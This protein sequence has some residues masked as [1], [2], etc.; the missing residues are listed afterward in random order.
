MAERAATSSDVIALYPDFS[1]V[2]GALLT[3]WL[4][5]TEEMIDAE[6]FGTLQ[7][8]AQAMLTAHFIARIPGSDVAHGATATSKTEG[9]IAASYAVSILPGDQELSSTKYGL[10]FIT[11]RDS[12]LCGPIVGGPRN[13]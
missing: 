11:V 3:T 7:S 8:Q 12:V 13:L 6:C 10:D 5:V 9:S 2:A 1:L 4:E